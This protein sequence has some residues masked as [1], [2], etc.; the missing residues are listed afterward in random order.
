[1]RII[2][3]ALAVLVLIAPAAAQSLVYDTYGYDPLTG[4]ER[5]DYLPTDNSP[6]YVS[7]YAAPPINGSPGIPYTGNSPLSSTWQRDGYGN[8][9]GVGSSNWQQSCKTDIYGVTVCE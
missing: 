1:M 9:N 2:I 6:G 4:T 7:T 3:A 8:W 5:N